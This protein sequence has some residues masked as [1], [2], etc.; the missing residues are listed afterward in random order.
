MRERGTM[1]P[2]RETITVRDAGADVPAAADLA[3]KLGVSAVVAKILVARGLTTFDECKRFFRPDSSQFHDPFL[4]HDMEKACDRVFTAIRDRETIIIYGDYDVDGV[5]ATALLIR[6]LRQFGAQCDY[7]L[8]NRLTEGYGLSA[9]GVRTIAAQG[10]KLIITVDCGITACDEVAL[11]GSLGIDVIVTDHH[12]PKDAVPNAYAI[13]DPKLASCGYPDASLAGVGVALKLGQG[14]VRR[15]GGDEDQWISFL[16]LAALGTA[17]D[18]V[19]LR[20]ENRV[21]V[22]LGFGMLAHTRNPGLFALLSAQD[23][24]GSSL[25]TGDVVFRIAPCINASGR[26]GD[27]RRGVELLLTD[28]TSTAALIAQELKQANIERRAIDAKIQEEAFAW[29]EENCDPADDYAI[30]AGSTAWHCGV[31]GIVA[32]KLVEKYHRP[33]ILFAI[34]ENGVARGSGRSISGFHL[35]EALASCSGLLESFGGHAAAAGMTLKHDNLDKFRLQINEVARERLSPEDLLPRITADAEVKMSDL[36]PKL[37]SILKQMEPFG[38]GNMRPVLVCRY[39]KNKYSPKIVGKNHLKLSVHDGGAAMDAVAFNF[40]DRL[41]ELVA[42]REFTLAFTLDEN[43]WNGR[44]TL[45][46]KIRGVET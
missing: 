29:V 28:N 15:M 44:T 7:Y 41:D 43:E 36:T 31:V 16:A 35:H 12:E 10:A 20:G 14:L 9:E 1:R 6:L 4:F 30:V 17:A 23:C 19:P 33:A 11:A 24:A 34:G 39:V 46:L 45:Q 37:Y 22:A 8:P 25:S 2:A 13:L 27:S 38:P 3:E 21:I 5:T 26:L 40:G 32:S 18:I 42:A